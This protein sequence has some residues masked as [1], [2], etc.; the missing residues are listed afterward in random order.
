M[1]KVDLRTGDT[2]ILTAENIAG[3]GEGIGSFNGFKIF[4][5]NLLPGET[6]KVRLIEVRKQ[7]ARGRIVEITDRS[8][9][10]VIPACKYFEECGACQM[11]HIDYGAQLRYKTGIVKDAVKK[12]AGLSEDIVLEIIPSEL[13]WGYRNKMQFPVKQAAGKK[14]GKSK[15]SMGYYR[16]GTHDVV[17]I[18]DCPVL[19]PSLNRIAGALRQVFNEYGASVFDEDSGR[20]LLRH[21][22]SRAAFGTGEHSVT[23][24]INERHFPGSN[25]L[26]T[27]F[28]EVLGKDVKI[29]NISFNSNTRKT[30]VILGDTTKT[31]LGKDHIIEKLEGL[32]FEIS[33]DSF[34]QINPVQAAVLF[35]TALKLADLKGSETVLDLY[36]GTGAISLYMARHAKRLYGVEEIRAAISDAKKNA[37]RNKINNA[38]FR[39]D[40]VERQIKKL[41]SEGIKAD[42]VVLDPPRAG[43][44]I[45]VLEY[46]SGFMPE[47]I[48]YVSCDPATL[49]RDIKVLSGKYSVDVIQPVDMFPQTAHVECVAK[50]SRKFNR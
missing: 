8:A 48:I 29:S 14:S 36:C 46:I 41:S 7:Y 37:A 45:Q 9:E 34:F 23:F 42:V 1:E 47:K 25:K 28:F 21:V 2:I 27:R 24:V 35:R 12:I 20:G 4:V 26:I 3:G 18:E 11:Q 38:V 39:C 16:K 50:L 19:Y 13:K 5:E 44:D 33:P 22:L 43:C 6:A 49:A 10:R 15:I 17:D 30:N 32:E 40:T 31:I